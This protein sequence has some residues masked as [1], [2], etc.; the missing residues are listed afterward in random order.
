MSGIVDAFL[1]CVDS[2]LGIRDNIGALIHPVYL[3]TRTWFTDSGLTTPATAPEGYAKDSS[4]QLLPTPAL[5][6]FS[7]DIRLKDGG[8]VKQGDIILSGVSKNKYASTDLDGSLLGAN[9]QLFFAVGVKLY[10]IINV[11]EKYVTFNVQIRELS[12]QSRY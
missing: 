1:P 11:T 10:Q 2:I 9:I 12:N 5:K 6:D 8:S 3:V 7:Q 4:V